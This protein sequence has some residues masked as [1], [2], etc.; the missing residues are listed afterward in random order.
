MFAPRIAR[1]EPA[2]LGDRAAFEGR[3]CGDDHVGCVRP[4]DVGVD[5]PRIAER[6]GPASGQAPATEPEGRPGGAAGRLDQ[7]DEH[8]VAR[9][10][11][12][13][14]DGTLGSSARHGIDQLEPVQ[15]EA[16][17]RLRQVRDLEA[18]VV[19]TLP[20]RARNRAT[21]VVSSVGWT[22]STF[23]SPTLR[24][25][26]RTRSEVMSMIVSSS[27]PSMSRQRPSASSIDWT[28]RCDVMDLAEPADRGGTWRASERHSWFDV[29]MTGDERAR[30]RLAISPRL[31]P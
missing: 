25:A 2:V 31:R 22:S 15:L 7:F 28:I 14:C 17:E 18:H 8:S 3:R 19:E 16:D 6:R 5:G 24:K 21:P 23:D 12:D 29:P 13:E 27:R 26:I 4:V 1:H 11:M 20:L 30:H 10:R 9:P